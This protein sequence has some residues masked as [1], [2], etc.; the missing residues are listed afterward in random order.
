MYFVFIFL[1]CTFGTLVLFVPSHSTLSEPLFHR[2]CI[3]GLLG[4]Y[5]VIIVSL[6]C[7]SLIPSLCHLFSLF[8]FF[9]LIFGLF[10]L[11]NHFFCQNIWSIQI[12]VVL[13][14]PRTFRESE[15][16]TGV[17]PVGKDCQFGQSFFIYSSLIL[18]LL[19]AI[20]SLLILRSN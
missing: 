18:P 16:W 17:S 12:F 11:K 3:D 14:Q 9:E 10:G 15:L 6:L 4:D 19:S 7:D 5:C 2:T 13:L 20:F 1:L 8:I